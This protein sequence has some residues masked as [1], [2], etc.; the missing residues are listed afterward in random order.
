MRAKLIQGKSSDEI[1]SALQQGMA[2]DSNE[3]K[4]K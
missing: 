3:G 2:D 1:Q 4:I